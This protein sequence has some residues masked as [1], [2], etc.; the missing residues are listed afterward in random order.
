M[1]NRRG[2]PKKVRLQ[3]RAGYATGIAAALV[4][5]L[6]YPGDIDPKARAVGLG[7]LLLGAGL[8]ARASACDEGRFVAGAGRA[9]CVLSMGV[10]APFALGLVGSLIAFALVPS[11]A[12]MFARNWTGTT[13]VVGAGAWL[14]GFAMV[15]LFVWF[16]GRADERPGEGLV[17][18]GLFVLA[19]I[20]LRRIRQ[21]RRRPNRESLP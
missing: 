7:V 21:L 17:S 16:A 15:V 20:L 18:A 3:V 1:K 10:A 6:G 9:A 8:L 4:A 12:G 2:H 19:A 11:S 13:R 14:L 5:V